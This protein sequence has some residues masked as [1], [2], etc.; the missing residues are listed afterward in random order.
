MKLLQMILP[1]TT[2]DEKK[3]KAMVTATAMEMEMGRQLKP[4]QPW[5]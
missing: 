1:F 2:W 3:L 5:S 4:L